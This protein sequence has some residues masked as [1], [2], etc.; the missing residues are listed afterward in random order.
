MAYEGEQVCLHAL[1]SAVVD[2]TDQPHTSAA[3][4]WRGNV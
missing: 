2:T 3:C 1:T 4:L